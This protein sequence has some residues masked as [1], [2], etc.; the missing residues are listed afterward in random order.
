MS[1]ALCSWLSLFQDPIALRHRLSPA[2]PFS[3]EFFTLIGHFFPINFGPILLNLGKDQTFTSLKYS[4]YH[5]FYIGYDKR[6]AL[7]QRF[8]QGILQTIAAICINISQISK[9]SGFFEEFN[10]YFN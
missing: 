3:I 4:L 9:K 7:F 1:T 6:Q 5:T 2:L 8:L 10:C